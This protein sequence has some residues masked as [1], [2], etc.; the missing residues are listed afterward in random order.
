MDTK[1][2]EEALCE[3][4]ELPSG[5][6]QY[7]CN[8]EDIVVLMW[9]F[10]EY[11]AC[12]S[13]SLQDFRF[14]NTLERLFKFQNA[15]PKGNV[16]LPYFILEDRESDVF[17]DKENQILHELYAYPVESEKKRLNALCK[18]LQANHY[19][20][21]SCD[22]SKTSTHFCQFSGGGDFYITKDISS[23]LV[24]AVPTD[25]NSPGT[26]KDSPDTDKD[27]P[28]TESA[29]EGSSQSSKVSPKVPGESKLVSFN[30]EG[31]KDSCNIQQLKFQLWA[32]MIILTVTKFKESLK[33][34]TKQ[35]LLELVQFTGYGMACGGDGI[36][37]VFKLE[38]NIN[39]GETTFVTKI[40]LGY[41]DRLQAARLMDFTFQYYKQIISDPMTEQD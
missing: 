30:I 33:L 13:A 7:V 9:N 41:R 14:I 35:Q 29:P 28:A 27:S 5:D 36:V 3:I 15:R 24:F 6:L 34:F 31:K 21:N 8:I 12:R 26:D 1:C 4:I 20:V 16:S 18:S 38:M 11:T 40:P 17:L 25:E 32:N 39:T 23:V 2:L 10:E 37:G 19:I 22:S